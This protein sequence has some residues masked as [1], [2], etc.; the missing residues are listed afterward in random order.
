MAFFEFDLAGAEWVIVAY[1]SGD[2]NMLRVVNG[3]RSPHV[4]TGSL[5]SRCPES[6]V[7]TEHKLLGSQTDPVIISQL[8]QQLP[9]L[10]E[11]NYFLPRTMSIR[12]CGKKAN[13][14]LNY[15]MKHRKFALFNEIMEKEAETIV[16]A[17]AKAYPGIP[18]WH[19]SIRTELK[20][21]RQL[22]NCF[23]RTVRFFDEFTYEL[24]D[25]GYSFKPQSTVADCVGQA[26][27]LF[28][29]D[30]KPEFARAKLAAQV[31]DS[32]LFEM[33]TNDLA[34][35]VAFSQT[36]KNAMTPELRYRDTTFR[37]K[38]DLKVGLTWGEMSEVKNT[39]SETFK[40]L[41]Q[42]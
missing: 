12:Q 29:N 19:T 38:C 28:F 26:I 41:F 32:V 1:L 39:S 3:T 40:S 7:E 9:E 42:L 18:R 14:G 37:L 30:P 36:F 35:C 8:R 10:Y 27:K 11:G 25:A 4:E 31:H 15:G 16:S 33:P 24:F 22:K 21:S 20:T 5:I 34:E 17:Y 6:L 23:G 2:E 13:H